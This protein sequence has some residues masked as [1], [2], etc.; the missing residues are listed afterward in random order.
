MA[1]RTHDE[2]AENNVY[3]HGTFGL[4]RQCHVLPCALRK[5]PE[6]FGLS[7]SKSWYPHYFN[8]SATLHYVG[9]MSDFSFYGADAMSDGERREFLQWYDGQKSKIFD[10]RGVKITVKRTLRKACHVFR[11]EF[12]EIENIEVLSR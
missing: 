7:A 12:M 3:A 10:N 8:T 9:K 2:R 4:P 6:A 5:L 11:R 1:A